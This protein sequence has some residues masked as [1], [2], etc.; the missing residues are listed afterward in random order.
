VTST[1]VRVEN[2]IN[3]SVALDQDQANASRIEEHHLSVRR[4]GQMPAPDH[5]RIELRALRGIAHGNAEVSVFS[6]AP[7]DAPLLDLDWVGPLTCYSPFDNFDEAEF[8][9][10]YASLAS[11]W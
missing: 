7:C 8:R 4:G 11:F 3:R 1:S 2:G 5:L 10:R 9:G 6:S